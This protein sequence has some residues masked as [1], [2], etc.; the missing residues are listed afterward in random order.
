M[1][2]LTKST[3][4]KYEQLNF[5][6]DNH[7]NGFSIIPERG[8]ILM[9][10]KFDGKSIVDSYKKASDLDILKWGKNIVLYP[11]PNRLKA[12]KYNFE[13]KE[14]QFP[15]NEKELK[16]A[17]HGFGMFQKMRLHGYSIS[18]HHATAVF[19]NLNSG[20]NEAYPFPHHFKIQFSISSNNEIEVNLV[21]ENKGEGNLPIGLGWHPYFKLANK[22]DSCKL[23]VPDDF[24]MEEILVN[25]K[26]LPTGK[27]K[28]SKVF[29]TAEKIGQLELD[30]CF[31]ISRKNKNDNF[32]FEMTLS[33]AKNKFTF[34]QD[35]SSGNM[36]YVQ[37]FIPPKRNCIAIE[38]MTCNI[39]AFNN[40]EG[41]TVLAPG[42]AL[43]ADFGIRYE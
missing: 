9:D 2:K 14:Y 24:E 19:S 12:G 13:G 28:K 31:K 38:P 16:N 20:E 22:V 27:I 30:S 26:M 23:S 29:H 4:G 33:S 17:L 34:W 39:N 43:R 21:F 25:K 6:S 5:F 41:L 1:Y 35:F 3:F 37:L 7:Q 11:F 18:K 42:K 10:L 15:I 36:D 40:A 32:P 8:A